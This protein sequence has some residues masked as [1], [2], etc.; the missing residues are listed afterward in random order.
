MDGKWTRRRSLRCREGSQGD[1]YVLVN[2][3]ERE[4]PLQHLDGWIVPRCEVLTSF[5]PLVAL[6]IPDVE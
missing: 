4:A 1:V 6:S 3:L 2:T 5:L